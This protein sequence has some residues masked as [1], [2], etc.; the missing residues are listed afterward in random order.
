MNTPPNS[1]TGGERV[2]PAHLDH[3]RGLAAFRVTKLLVGTHLGLSVLTLIAVTLLRDDP[4][5]VSPAV[6]VRTTIV[7][8]SALVTYICAVRA[9]DGS[10]PAYRRLRIISAVMTAAIVAIIALRG[11]FPV[12]FKAE[13]AVCGAL[14]IAL[15]ALIN[16]K[17]LRSLFASGR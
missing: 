2:S 3:P 13:Q 9:A 1:H 7:V 14:L 12:W 11:T 6:W 4:A 10:R 5:Q 16:G 17:H 15:L 8:A